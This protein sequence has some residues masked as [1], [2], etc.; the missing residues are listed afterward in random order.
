MDNK[1]NA[2]AILDKYLANSP[3]NVHIPS[4]IDQEI[5][6]EFVDSTMSSLEQLEEAILAFESGQIQDDFVTTARR[7]LHNIKGEAGIMDISEICN[8]CHHAESM[9]YDDGKAVP[10]DMLLS[11]KDWLSRS[12]Q[13][14]MSAGS[15]LSEHIFR[16]QCIK[17]LWPAEVNLLDMGHG[18]SDA[19]AVQTVSSA[20][21]EI[22]ELAAQMAKPEIKA[23]TEKAMDLLENIQHNERCIISD[24][25]KESLFDLLD[26]IKQHALN[27]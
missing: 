12:M 17:S 15:E 9:L 20:M 8:I 27:S 22:T 24:V 13:Y 25:H 11:V 2:A 23:L 21:G 7:I 18:T 5:L 14:L 26:A 4:D 3:E 6:S 10:V 16:S 19:Q 1:E